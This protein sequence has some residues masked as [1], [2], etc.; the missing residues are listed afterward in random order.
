MTELLNRSSEKD[1]R[2]R[3][4][5]ELT[6]AETE[7]WSRLRRGQL[8]GRRFPRQYSIGP[9]CVDFYCVQAKLAIE[10][11]G[12]SHFTP[13]AKQY[14]PQRQLYIEAFGIRFLRFTN[15]EVY[16]NLDGV[17]EA[18]ARALG[19]NEEPPCIPPS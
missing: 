10:V 8:G 19:L 13:E 4:R 12:D 6:P 17:I 11:D 15:V 14:D 16:D 2:R 9:Y 5:K 18:I 7:L 3:L 1:L